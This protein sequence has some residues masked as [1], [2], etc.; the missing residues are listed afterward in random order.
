MAV[1]ILSQMTPLQSLTSVY[2]YKYYPHTYRHF[3]RVE[4]YA[5]PL[6]S[7]N[8]V[9]VHIYAVCSCLLNVTI[10]TSSL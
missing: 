7:F 9:A 2:K 10:Q 8:R 5:N 4:M 1:P 6:F 3:V